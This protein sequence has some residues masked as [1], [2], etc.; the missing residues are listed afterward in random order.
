[1]LSAELEFLC[2]LC[3]PA[4]SDYPAKSCGPARRLLPT[5]I[6]ALQQLASG[7]HFSMRAHFPYPAIPFWRFRISS[8]ETKCYPDA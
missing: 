4:L 8:R 5:S 2:S 6:L 3:S 1:M 7:N